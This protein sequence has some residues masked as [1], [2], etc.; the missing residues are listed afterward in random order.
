[1]NHVPIYGDDVLVGGNPIGSQL[2]DG[3]SRMSENGYISYSFLT[4]Q[5]RA[6]DALGA[7]L[8]HVWPELLQDIENS[9]VEA[10]NVFDAVIRF[11]QLF[12]SIVPGLRTMNNDAGRWKNISDLNYSE[13]A[14]S[15]ANLHHRMRT[16]MTMPIL[17][18]DY[19]RPMTYVQYWYDDYYNGTSLQGKTFG[20]NWSPNG[21]LADL[22]HWCDRLSTL[23]QDFDQSGFHP[24]RNSNPPFG[25]RFVR[26]GHV[27]LW[28]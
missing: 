24:R 3:F 13:G 17:W 21:V 18:A 7:P 11:H 20:H 8:L 2:G 25:S 19:N 4:H 5:W 15:D 23:T 12:F 9:D 16:L 1:M 6:I 26:C 28:V 22:R 27:C 10:Q 14:W